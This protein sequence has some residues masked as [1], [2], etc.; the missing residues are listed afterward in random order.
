MRCSIK[1]TLAYF[2]GQANAGQKCSKTLNKEDEL[3][4]ER[5]SRAKAEKGRQ[6][7]SRDKCYKTFCNLRF[8]VIR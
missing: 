2:A 1:S 6:N 8:F 4:V 3:A 5:Q 7:L